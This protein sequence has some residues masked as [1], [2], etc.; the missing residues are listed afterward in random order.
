MKVFG[1]GLNKSASSSLLDAW[2]VLGHRQQIYWPE[3][4]PYR[5]PMV[6]SAFDKNYKLMFDRVD[7]FT[8]FKDRPFNVWDTY[9][10]LDKHYL[11]CKFILTTRDE[12]KWWDSVDRWLNNLIP[13]HHTTEQMR[14][15]KIEVYKHHFGATEFDK[16]QFISYYRQYNQEVRDYFKGKDNFLE[17]DIPAGDGW[18]VLCPFLGEDIPNVAFPHAN[19]NNIGKV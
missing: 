11:D 2:D 6:M 13:N 9:K 4:D 5:T 17:M 3:A 7:R 15:H 18:N 16:D 19:I 8:Y 1:I 12:N 14:L 10:I